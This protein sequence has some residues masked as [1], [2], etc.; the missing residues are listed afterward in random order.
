MENQKKKDIVKLVNNMIRPVHFCANHK[1]QRT[2][3][4]L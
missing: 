2:K 4:S 1:D 3:Y